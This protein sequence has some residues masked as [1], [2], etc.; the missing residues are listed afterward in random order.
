M[1]VNVA[2]LFI[3][4]LR[5]HASRFK[6]DEEEEGAREVGGLRGEL[7]AGTASSETETEN[8][9]YYFCLQ[10]DELRIM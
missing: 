8:R 4:M 6:S 5:K 1:V 10:E 2:Y 9:Q 7:G 3:P